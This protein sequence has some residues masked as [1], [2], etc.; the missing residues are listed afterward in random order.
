MIFVRKTFMKIIKHNLE[1]KEIIYAAK[2]AE[3]AFV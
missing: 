3:V 1:R 2:K